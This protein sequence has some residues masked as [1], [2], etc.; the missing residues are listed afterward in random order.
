MPLSKFT[1]RILWIGFIAGQWTRRDKVQF[2]EAF[3][4]PVTTRS[5]GVSQRQRPNRGRGLRRLVV[6]YERN[7]EEP[8]L[9]KRQSDGDK[10]NT[11]TTGSPLE[12]ASHSI[13]QR[14]VSPV[15]DD[16]GL[17]L[18]DALLAQIVAPSLQIFWIFLVHA[19]SPSWLRPL[20]SYFGEAPELAPRGSLLAPT[21][22]HGAGLAVCWLAGALA[23]RMYEKEA[24]SLR[25]LDSAESSQSRSFFE[26]ALRG[27]QSYD[28]VVSR[29]VK[30]GAFATGILIVGTQIDLLLEFKRYV[31]VGETEETDLR[32]LVAMVEVINDVVFEAVVLSSWRIIHAG[33]MSNAENRSKRW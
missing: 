13:L 29:L 20:S 2:S 14:F 9:E 11:S 31:Q 8:N 5:H 3:A 27:I 1:L 16:P 25:E 22:I 6:I 19:P 17:P 24:F 33:F 21:L 32:L 28:T 15:I 23:A 26:K 12:N 18:T 7:D 30:A 4:P 10:S